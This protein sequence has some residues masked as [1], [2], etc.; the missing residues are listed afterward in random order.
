MYKSYTV[1]PHSTFR[2]AG[3]GSHRSAWLADSIPNP[4]AQSGPGLTLDISGEITDPVGVHVQHAGSGSAI[5]F[6]AN[7]FIYTT[8]MA[9]CFAVCAVWG[10]KV[11]R[12]FPNGYLAHVSNPHQTFFAIALG[13]IPQGAWIVVDVGPGNAG[14]GNWGTVIAN[15]IHTIHHH[16]EDHIWI[17]RRGPQGNAGFGIN[18]YGRFGET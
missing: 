8:G 1:G 5:D 10:V 18:K 17:Y 7:E 16:A 3:F 2:T 13:N 14:P 9:N 15:K 4:L 11:G 12:A 6:T